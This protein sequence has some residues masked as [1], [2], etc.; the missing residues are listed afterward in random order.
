MKARCS[1]CPAFS[2][3]VARFRA[4]RLEIYGLALRDLADL[5][6]NRLTQCRNTLFER[7]VRHQELTKTSGH[8]G[9]DAKR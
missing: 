5:V 7:R 1:R 9:L 4:V 6:G 3:R 8:A 2:S